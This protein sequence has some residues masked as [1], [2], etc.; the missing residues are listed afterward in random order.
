M[1]ALAK[2]QKQCPQGLLNTVTAGQ[3][4]VTEGEK[5]SWLERGMTTK[6]AGKFGGTQLLHRMPLHH[7]AP[8]VV[9]EVTS[10]H[11]P[12]SILDR[13]AGAPRATSQCLSDVE[14]T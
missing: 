12:A 8:G 1:Q 9:G 5:A 3:W 10:T 2:R 7:P 4:R 11:L 14:A 13:K 6:G